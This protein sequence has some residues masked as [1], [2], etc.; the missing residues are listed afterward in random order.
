[1]IK[2]E[3]FLI[4]LRCQAKKWILTASA[5]VASVNIL[6]SIWAKAG[7]PCRY[8]TCEMKMKQQFF[9][10]HTPI[11]RSNPYLIVLYKMCHYNAFTTRTAN[12]YETMCTIKHVSKQAGS[13]QLTTSI[14]AALLKP[15]W[16][17]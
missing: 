2:C 15:S 11:K 16:Q 8:T 17:L 6:K 9:N 13:F 7:A 14:E 5:S 1:M 12:C 10:L 4:L 3:K